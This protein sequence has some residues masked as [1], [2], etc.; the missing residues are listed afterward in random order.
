MA[1][2]IILYDWCSFTTS[3][4]SAEELIDELGLSAY[5]WELKNGVRGYEHRLFFN[6]ISV[7]YGGEVHDHVWVEMSGQGCRAFET[8][9][10]GDWNKLFDFI[11][12]YDCNLTR[13][14]VA[15]DERFGVL[16]ILTIVQDTYHGE[17]VSRARSWET[18]CSNKGMS[19]TI[20]SEQ[21]DVLIRIYDK[22]AERHCAAGTKW[23]RVEIQFRRE[24]AAGFLNL[25]GALGDRFAGVLLNY[26]RYVDADP[27]DTNRWRW[28]MKSYWAD[29]L[30]GAAAVSVFSAPGV[31]YNID[32]CEDFVYRQ[33]GNA[34]T[35]LIDIYGVDTFLDRLKERKSFMSDKY[36]KL[37]ETYK[38]F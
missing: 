30:C 27:A 17:Y 21:S 38:G 16:D 24:R 23:V 19:V 6:S 32:R 36:K 8:Y 31:D 5:S 33:A 10:H 7:H 9:G 15:Y 28:P 20:G 4:F 22:A 13:L 18:V 29:L 3:K 1:I 37:I 35:A 2:D 34:I 25:S 14:D 11:R 12:L 26:L